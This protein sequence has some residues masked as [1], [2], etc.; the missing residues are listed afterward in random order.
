[1]ASFSV[2]VAVTRDT[3]RSARVTTDKTDF[4]EHIGASG[5]QLCPVPFFFHLGKLF[6]L[7]V[8]VLSFDQAFVIQNLEMSFL[9]GQE[10]SDGN[11]YQIKPSRVVFRT[12][13]SQSWNLRAY[14]QSIIL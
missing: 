13:R 4:W 5:S 2:L 7:L 3:L 11:P 6:I 9:E 8:P 14:V 1:M 12:S 10:L